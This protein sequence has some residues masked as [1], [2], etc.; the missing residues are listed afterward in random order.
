MAR[1][2]C[3]Q[4]LRRKVYSRCENIFFGQLQSIEKKCSFAASKTTKAIE[5]WCNGSTTVFGTVCVGSNPAS[6]TN[7]LSPGKV[8]VFL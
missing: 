8:G 2:V 6:S 3:E 4:P 1:A 5:L 7:E